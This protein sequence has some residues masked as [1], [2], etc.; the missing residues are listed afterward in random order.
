MTGKSDLKCWF[1]LRCWLR[2][3]SGRICDRYLNGRLQVCWEC[4]QCGK[5]RSWDD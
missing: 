3:C 2:W 1:G 5:L 4:R